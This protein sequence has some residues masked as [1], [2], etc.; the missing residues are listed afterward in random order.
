MNMK[1][2]NW[3]GFEIRFVEKEPNEWWAVLDDLAKALDLGQTAPIKRRLPKEVISNHMVDFGNGSRKMLIVNELGIYETVFESRKKEAKEFKRWVFEVV[4]TLRQSSGLEGFQIFRMLDKEH[5]KEMMSKLNQSLQ[6]PKPVNF[7][8]ANTIA[9]KAVS[10]RYGHPKMLKKN[11][12]TPDM[13]VEREPILADAVD[14][15][16]ANE[17]FQLGLS[18]SEIVYGKYVH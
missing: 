2:E 13:L 10:S 4:K 6:D 7:I 14:L 3:N 9:N 8:K 5:Q 1:I 12:M 16:I 17:K 18:V 15:M 11:Q